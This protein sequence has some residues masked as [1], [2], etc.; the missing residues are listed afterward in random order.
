MGNCYSVLEGDP[1][2]CFAGRLKCF[3]KTIL[4]LLSGFSTFKTNTKEKNQQ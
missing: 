4:W 1:V 3:A 2:L